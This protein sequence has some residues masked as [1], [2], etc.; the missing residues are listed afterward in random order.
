ME[1][2]ANSTFGCCPDNF[3]AAAGPFGQDCQEIK[4]CEEARFGCCRDGATPAKGNDFEGCPASTC[5]ETLS[6]TSYDIVRKQRRGADSLFF[7]DRFG[8]CSDGETE[9]GG[10]DGEG[11]DENKLCE[12][13][14]FGCCPDDRTFAQGPKKQG[15]FTCPEEVS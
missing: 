13:S 1:P 11:C 9:A 10:P 7:V 12:N 3:F 5:E 6:V 2:C 8:C 14:Q 15:C 4:T